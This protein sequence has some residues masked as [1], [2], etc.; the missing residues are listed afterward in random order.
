MPYNPDIHHRRSIRLKGYDYSQEGL[1][2]V[3]ICVQNR[4]CLFGRIADKEMI[5]NEYG[6]IAYDEWF[7][8][9]NIRSNVQLDAFV[10]MPNHIHGIIVI[11]NNDIGRGVSHTPSSDNDA[12]NGHEHSNTPVSNGGV[13]DTPL[14]SPANTIGAIIRGYKS[15][16]TR[17]MR[18]LGFLD[19]IWQRNYYEYI[20]RNEQAYQNISDYIIHNSEKWQDDKFYYEEL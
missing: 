1:Y 4:H 17:Q 14:R 13:C 11:T 16:V 20:I 12:N 7:K 3:T 9:P 8:T 6:K 15:A 18:E 10:V 2:F 5:L 19:I